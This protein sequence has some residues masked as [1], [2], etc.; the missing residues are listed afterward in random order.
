[1]YYDPKKLQAFASQVMQKTGL[2][3]E[4]SDLFAESL[5]RADMRGMKSHGV[6]RLKTYS[7]RLEAGLVDAGAEPEVLRDNPALILIDGKNALGVP[8]A[9]KA[10]ELCVDH[11]K[12]SG[13]CFAAVR[14]GN[15]YGI[16][17]FYTDF[18]AD[19]D[20]IGFAVANA[21]KAL[22]PIGGKEP[23]LGTNPLSVS[24]PAGRYPNMNLDMATSIVARGKVTLAKKNGESIPAG[25]GIDANGIVT[26]D[27]NQVKC[28][29][30]FGGYKG[31][32]IGLIIEILSS[33]LSGAAT[34]LT[35]GSFYDFS[36]KIQ[37]SGF[38]LGAINVAAIMEPD[39]FRAEVDNL[40]DSVK[41][42]P[43]ADGCEQIYLPGEIELNKVALA[44]E[45]GVEI[46]DAV[47]AELREISERYGVPFSC[48]M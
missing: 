24:I 12:Q 31:Y 2:S 35:M 45:R 26:T 40:F 23:L 25:W 1:M 32:A 8:T 11:A 38:F 48:E 42:I 37:N 39:A 29:L 19:H 18:A 3:R 10:M 30:P 41:A 47:L 16:G 44:E 14:G 36:G 5:I 7:Y 20:M 4:K 22:A 6:T 33:C 15:H 28:M 34:G 21:P 17:E 43:L 9:M 27:P 13:A 46:T